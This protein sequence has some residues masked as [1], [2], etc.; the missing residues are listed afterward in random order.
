MWS[1]VI[2]IDKSYDK[3][4]DYILK[5][6]QCAKDVSSSVEE[7][8]DRM[9]M[10]LASVCERQDDVEGEMV[11]LLQDVLLCYIKLRFFMS[12]LKIG[13]M[14]Y[15]KCA[16]LSS[17]VHFDREFENTI[18]SKTISKT[19]DYNV[20]GLLNFRLRALKEGWQEVSEVANR[21][22]EASMGDDDIFEISS[23]ICGSEG[24][25][26]RLH[27]ASNGL[28][29]QTIRDCVKIFNVFDND[30]YNLLFA[31]I[32]QKPSEIV[33]EGKEF[34]KEFVDTLKRFSRVIER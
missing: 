33:I 6:L 1:N 22:L 30:E 5:R 28:Y 21:L 32:S 11:S 3:E 16:L 10:Y 13:N 7:S 9:W 26:S 23:F 19:L 8:R 4:I 2:S 15:A 31:I 27:I 29:N 12:R 20:D 18:V 24:K 34:S 17:L 14:T 25:K